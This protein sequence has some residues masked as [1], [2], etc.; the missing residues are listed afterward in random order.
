MEVN[1]VILESESRFG[2]EET[3][4][5]I[6]QK[7]DSTGWK[8]PTVHDLQET[9]RKN[10]IDVLEVKVI[11]LC[12]PQYSGTLMKEDPTKFVSALMPCRISVYRK[13]NGK[14]YISRINAPMLSL[15][16]GG[17]IGQVMGQAGAEM[18]RIMK[19]ILVEEP[20]PDF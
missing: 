11:E 5:R 4:A 9:L 18:E 7:A 3:V 15:F 1:N 12:K 10:D 16:M 17:T 19:E 2:F 6:N 13:T 8:I 20:L 14:T